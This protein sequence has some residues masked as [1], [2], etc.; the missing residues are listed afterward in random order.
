MEVCS[1]LLGLYKSLIGV[2]LDF[3]IVHEYREKYGRSLLFWVCVVTYVSLLVWES[4]PYSFTEFS[5][6][7]EI[8]DDNIVVLLRLNNL[9]GLVMEVQFFVAEQQNISR[10]IYYLGSHITVEPW[11]AWMISTLSSGYEYYWVEHKY[12]GSRWKFICW[13]RL[14]LNENRCGYWYWFGSVDI[15]IVQYWSNA[16]DKGKVMWKGYSGVFVSISASRPMGVA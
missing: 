1:D 14:R 5:P 11:Q 7:G 16:R 8:N 13:W 4:D 3:W 15:D 10:N 6:G 9:S 2:S 12:F